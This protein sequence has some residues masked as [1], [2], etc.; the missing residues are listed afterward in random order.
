M[1][2]SSKTPESSRRLFAPQGAPSTPA[3][4][5]CLLALLGACSAPQEK[6]QK[7]APPD[8]TGVIQSFE[9]P[10][11]DLDAQTA[12]ELS[13][14]AHAL[15]AQ[16][17]ALGLNDS[18]VAGVLDAIAAR[19]RDT[20]TQS[21]GIATRRQAALTDQGYMQVTRICNGWGAM[22]IPDPVNGDMQLTVGFENQSIDPV[23]WGTFNLCRY[24]ANDKKIQLGGSQGARSG[25]IN[26]YF[27][28]QVPWAD[29]GRMPMLFAV[30]FGVELDGAP[31][32]LQKAF[33]IDPLLD[34]IELLQSTSEGDLFVLL[35]ATDPSLTQ[36][37]SVRA[38]NG[39]FTCDE[40]Q[41][42]CT[43]DSGET[44]TF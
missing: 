11:A 39:H 21:D 14:P 9:T 4:A 34:T 15:A 24:L 29:V 10:T 35:S 36:I 25:P 32:T 5:L 23:V 41:R 33:R 26:C 38:R 7:P 44:V 30:D 13:S 31:S 2:R 22:P 12:S 8:M 43:S 16:I 42:A 40:T 3:A 6:V 37:V 19:Q 20:Q 27:G 1:I 28:G 18:I 17:A